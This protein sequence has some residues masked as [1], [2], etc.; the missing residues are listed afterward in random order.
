MDKKT[1]NHE[2]LFDQMPVIRFLVERKDDI[3]IV[4][5][6]N[7]KGILFFNKEKDNIVGHA[8]EALIKESDYKNFLESLTVS[9]EKKLAVTLPTISGFSEE[10]AAPGFWINPILD[11]VGG[12]VCLDV[13]GQPSATDV[14]VV[15][16]ERNDALSLLTSIFNAS[17]VGILVFDSDRN[18]VKMNDSFEKI[19]GWGREETLDKDF[20]EFITEDEQEI[21]QESYQKF[22]N[23]DLSH[24]GE[25]KVFCKDGT[26]ANT[27]FTTAPLKLSNGRR[28][29]V[30]TLFN[31][32]KRK[33]MELS[34]RVAKERAD[35][36]NNAKSAFLANMSHELRTPLNAI[37]GFSEMMV[38]EA[39]GPL[40]NSKYKEYMA[41]VHMSAT[42]LLEIINEVLD[43]SKIEAGKV[44][45][46]EQEIDINRLLKTLVRVMN[47]RNVNKKVS[48]EVDLQGDIARLYADPRLLRQVFINLI[49]N[50]I[51]YSDNGGVIT[52]KTRLN[53]KDEIEVIISDEGVGIPKERIQDALE[54]FGQIHDPSLAHNK[55]YQG[56]GL[57]LPLAKAM[58]EMHGGAF[59]LQSAEGKGTT[60]IVGF[61]KARTR[62][63]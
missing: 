39:F 35:S 27:L 48:I 45:L 55:A 60:V 2:A 46:D 6:V 3:F 33:Q 1:V 29:Q 58:V 38:K 53:S 31:I 10:G 24:S 17:D 28:F 40:A 32:T 25:V 23:D 51:K 26:I 15:E 49:T 20:I 34:L 63:H 61:S 13:I 19:Y 30:T 56:T 16:R 4:S 12:V 44:V 42:H 52:I 7:D 54:P 37:I 62:H 5:G 11:D 59:T 36:A 8:L 50:S 43:M 57:G 14:S 41:D 47:S 18:I 22:L 9:F 21:T